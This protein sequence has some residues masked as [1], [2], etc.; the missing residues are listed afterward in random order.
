[1]LHLWKRRAIYTGFGEEMK[2]IDHF[3]D[4]GVYRRIIFT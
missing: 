1:M 4:E 3:E 2:K